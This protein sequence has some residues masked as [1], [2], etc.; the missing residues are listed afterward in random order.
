MK[1]TNKNSLL[2]M[3]EGNKTKESMQFES[4]LIGFFKMRRLQ[5]DKIQIIKA[6]YDWDDRTQLIGVYR[7]DVNKIYLPD[8]VCYVGAMIGFEVA[9]AERSDCSDNATI[10]NESGF[11]ISVHHALL[12]ED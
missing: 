12:V 4:N 8:F 10:V 1:T 6:I 11:K 7:V 9:E 2:V 5:G 3:F